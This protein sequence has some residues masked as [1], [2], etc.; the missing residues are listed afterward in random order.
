MFLLQM[1]DEDSS[2]KPMNC[3]SHLLMFQHRRRSYRE[4]P[5]RIADFAP[6]HRNEIRGVLSRVTR[7]RKFEQDDA[8]IFCTPDQVQSEVAGCLDFVRFVY[9]KVFQMPYV[10]RLSTRPPKFLGEPAQWDRAEADLKAALDKSGIAYATSP[11][12]GAFYGPKIDFDMKDA[13]GRSW[14]LSTVQLDFQLP[15]RFKAEYEG[16]DGHRHTPVMIHRAILGSLERFIAVLTEHYAGEFP[17]WIAPVQ[18]VVI[19]IGEAEE[20][21][22]K[23]VHAKLLEEGVRA[24]LD[25]SPQRVSYKIREATLQKVPYMLVCGAREA[26]AGSVSVRERKAG[27][28]GAVPA[29]EFI[30]KL[31]R[32]I[33]VQTA[34]SG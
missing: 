32:D 30:E 25:L 21:Y 7:V 34:L 6:L 2:L 29:G 26:A 13:I 23:S 4:L 19:P 20:A 24:E 27:D 8:H 10:A 18:A 3:P 22:A 14:Q 15:L 16:A 17:L 9:D 31:R 5:W 28:L 1:D 11:G 12:E 33:G